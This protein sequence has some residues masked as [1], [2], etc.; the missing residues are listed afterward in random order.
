MKP[1]PCLFLVLVFAG[2]P[3]GSYSQE[4]PAS[5]HVTCSNGRISLSAREIP[6]PQLLDEIRQAANLSLSVFP[7]AEEEM[8]SAVLKDAPL[9]QGLRTLLG[10]YDSI[11]LYSANGRGGA[12]LKKVWVYRKGQATGL[13]PASAESVA[14]TKALREKLNDPDAAIRRRAFD[15]LLS[16]PGI[17]EREFIIQAVLA[18][19][20][21]SLRANML[22][23]VRSSGLQLP[24]DFW[25]SLAADPSEH[26]RLLVLDSLEGTM[27]GQ[28]FAS[29]ALS[30]PSPH[31]QLRAKE[32]LDSLP[33]ARPPSAQ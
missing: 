15:A 29:L 5:S 13:E 18:E 2:A 32:I 4:A 17:E 28:N 23:S 30:D 8:I 7:G 11:F 33:S 12:D 3:T 26:V 1:Y 16:R 6:L 19:R 31:V 21:D 20:E 10:S 14:G 9:E 27:E 25:S 22:E 24:P